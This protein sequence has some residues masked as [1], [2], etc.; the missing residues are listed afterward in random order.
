MA[1]SAQRMR[2]L[3]ARRATSPSGSTRAIGTEGGGLVVT[4]MNQPLTEI[5]IVD[6]VRLVYFDVIRLTSMVMS[7][8]IQHK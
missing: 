7:I 1:T 3:N 2:A 5:V 8:A 4:A 6:P